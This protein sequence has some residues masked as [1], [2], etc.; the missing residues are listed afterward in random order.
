[1]AADAVPLLMATA[2]AAVVVVRGRDLGKRVP[3]VGETEVASLETTARFTGGEVKDLRWAPLACHTVL[4]PLVLLCK[5]LTELLPTLETGKDLE[6]TEFLLRL[7]IGALF[8]EVGVACGDCRIMAVLLCLIELTSFC[9][10]LGLSC[11][12]PLVAVWGR[13][14]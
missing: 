12:V 3:C 9:R 14:G 5:G 7:D 6:F 10:T 13:V 1:M 8:A 11:G 4:G 2:A